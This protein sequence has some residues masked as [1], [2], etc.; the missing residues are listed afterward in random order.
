MPRIRKLKPATNQLSRNLCALINAHFGG[1]IR[2][3]AVVIGVEYD[4][5]YRATTGRARTM[6]YDA[7]ATVALH[8]G[9]TL[10]VLVRGVLNPKP[11]DTP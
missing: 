6:N 4:A 7:A 9:T 5:L 10:D 2:D 8:F 3:A 1:N 11:G